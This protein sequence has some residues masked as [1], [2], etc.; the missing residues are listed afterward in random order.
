MPASAS[1]WRSTFRLIPELL[2]NYFRL[3]SRM[4]STVDH[5]YGGKLVLHQPKS[6]YR[7]SMD[8]CLL[9]A[10]ISQTKSIRFC[11]EFGFGSGLL[12]VGLVAAGCVEKLV[13]IEIQ[14]ELY[15][16][17]I[18]NVVENNCKEQIHLLNIDLRAPDLPDRLDKADAVVMNPPFWAINESRMPE[19]RQR[20][21]GGFEIYGS[22]SN[23]IEQGMRLMKNKRSRIFLVYPASKVGV[24][25]PN[26]SKLNM[27]AV[28]MRMV[29]PMR[30]S[31]A[32]LVL[33]ELR[34]GRDG[35]LRVEPPLYLKG[36]NGK[37]TAEAQRILNG[38]F[39]QK[40]SAMP[41]RRA[42]S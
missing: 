20:R 33:L 38:K 5:F 13:G 37:D 1:A 12:G 3:K 41:D 21:I 31:Y 7:S 23:W 14:S 28:R 36:L 35:S 11:V 34:K 42:N 17:G 24:F 6:G 25:M 16:L 19:N 9:T 27:C 39:T 4:D 22:I 15:E 30:D 18:K 32:E 29:H 26:A 8:A 2:D 40:L 10:F